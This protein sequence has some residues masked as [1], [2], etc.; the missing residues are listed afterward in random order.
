M[1]QKVIVIIDEKEYSILSSDPAEYVQKVSDHVD[2][3]VK[4]VKT[5]SKLSQ[6]DCYILAAMNIADEYYR[7]L[8]S[9]ESLR[10]QIKES[11]EENS[12][13]ARELAKCK[14]EMEGKK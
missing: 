6:S 2:Q 4:A 7:S 12:R 14:R 3:Q 8:E 11:L 9:A 10:R 1:N 13:L 5:G